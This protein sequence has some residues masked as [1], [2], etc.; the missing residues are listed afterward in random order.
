MCADT[1][2]TA[3]WDAAAAD[4]DNEP[5]HG[6]RDPAVREAWAARLRG[7]LPERAGDVL[8]L[9]CGTG[10]LALLAAERGHRVTG[11]DRSPRM[12]ELARAKLGGTGA[13]VLVGDAAEPPV[14]EGGFDV[15]LVRHL[16]WMLPDRQAVLR[17]WVRLLR[18]GG[19]LVLI[20]GRWGDS[21]P[22][23]LPAAE[24]SA[25]VGPVTERLSV[26]QLA[27]D[28]ALWGRVVRDER[29]ALVADL[30]PARRHTEI[31]DVHLILRR[32]DEVL[33]ARRA[34]TGYA[35]GL[36]HAP[37]GHVEDGEDVRAAMLRETAEEIGLTL[38]PD[39]VRVVL[40]LQHKAPTG[41]ARTGWFFEAEAGR[42][43]GLEPVNREPEKCSELGWFP[44]DALPD[45]MVAYCRAGLEAYRAGHRFALHWHEPDDPIGY[46][47]EGPDRLTPL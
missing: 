13:T 30:A 46:A 6:L 35:D 38:G 4:F 3:Y 8:D 41:A 31:V 1:S 28:A 16:L 39:E 43:S 22:V 9:G 17:R 45:D 34:N 40:V 24:L 29:Y 15:V 2:T 44:L 37:S 47:P 27:P 26:E 36:L 20:E 33:L 11:V 14:G 18:P 32:G 23:G 12:V 7:W 19:R 10:S 5:D 25:L 21:D 42:E